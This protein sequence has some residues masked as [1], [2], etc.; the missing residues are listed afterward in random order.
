VYRVE[1]HFQC[2]EKCYHPNA[3]LVIGVKTQVPQLNEQLF[4]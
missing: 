1:N 4:E 3:V 2:S